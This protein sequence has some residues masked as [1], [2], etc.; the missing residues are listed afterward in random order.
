MINL[1]DHGIS[2][3]LADEMG[4]GKT[5]Q[6]IS[7]MAHVKETKKTTLPHLVLVPKS[8]LG[9]WGRELAKFCPSLKVLKLQAADKEER[10]RM[11]R[12]ARR[13]QGGV[14]ECWS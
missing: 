11:V 8:V 1:N 5:L 3:I 14:C 9:N 12:R 7:L 6:S 4:L 13:G 10:T 2:G